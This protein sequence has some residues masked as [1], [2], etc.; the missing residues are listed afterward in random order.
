MLA[1]RTTTFGAVSPIVIPVGN[2]TPVCAATD[3]ILSDPNRWN[4]HR[5]IRPAA[6]QEVMVSRTV[7]KP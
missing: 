3:P 5:S 1:L 7:A 6:T 4:L 2:P